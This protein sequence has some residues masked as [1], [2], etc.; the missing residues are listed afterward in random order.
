MNWEE[1]NKQK[2][3]KTKKTSIFFSRMQLAS[4]TFLKAF[5]VL[6]SFCPL[7]F[8]PLKITETNVCNVK[9]KWASY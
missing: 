2:T 1:Y 9:Q 6:Q 5:L 3:P 7:V 4:W 8:V